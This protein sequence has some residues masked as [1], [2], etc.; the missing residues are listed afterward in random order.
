MTRGMP[1][2]D[3]CQAVHSIYFETCISALLRLYVFS[4]HLPPPPAVCLRLPDI[5]KPD[6]IGLRTL[7]ILTQA[8]KNG[9]QYVFDWREFVRACVLCLFR[10]LALTRTG[11]SVVFACDALGSNRLPMW[12]DQLKYHGGG[13]RRCSEGVVV[14]PPVSSRNSQRSS[15]TTR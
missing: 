5:F 15:S 6:R 8:A 1:R 9:V 13:A 2:T 14:L 11:I 12:L 4:L 7:E 10:L 3:Y